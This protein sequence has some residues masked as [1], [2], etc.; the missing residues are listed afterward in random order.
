MKQYYNVVSATNG[1]IRTSQPPL[2]GTEE[3]AQAF[4][5]CT[6]DVNDVKLAPI[7]PIDLDNLKKETSGVI[8]KVH[9]DMNHLF[10]YQIGPTNHNLIKDEDVGSFDTYVEKDYFELLNL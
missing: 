1:E 6:Y 4:L 7:K 2:Y 10:T 3:Q 9:H 5:E 8:V